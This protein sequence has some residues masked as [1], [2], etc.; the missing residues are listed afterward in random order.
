[1]VEPYDDGRHVVVV[2]TLLFA[3]YQKLVLLMSRKSLFDSSGVEGCA[4]SYQHIIGE[5]CRYSCGQ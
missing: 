2:L 1:M 3:A 4:Y 5:G